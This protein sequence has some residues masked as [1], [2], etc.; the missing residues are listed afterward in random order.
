MTSADVRVVV[1]D[2]AR[3]EVAA[4]L[5]DHL[6]A[7]HEY[8]PRCAV[9]AL[10]AAGVAA[11]DVTFWTAWAGIELAG[12]GAL[13]E[14]GPTRGEVKSM[15]TAPAH[16]RRGVAARIL[17]EVVGAAR[18]RGYLEL[19]LETGSGPAFDPAHALYR[20]FGFEPCGPFGDYPESPFS[21]FFRLALDAG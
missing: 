12:C 16:L 17:A 2:P 6:A 4:L 8:S 18:E 10:D 14:L 7:M 13:K 15:R 11:A 5:A 21:R 3:A 19:L 1:D 20:R 9:Y